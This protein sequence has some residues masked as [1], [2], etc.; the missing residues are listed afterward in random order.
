MR[1]RS[2]PVLLAVAASGCGSEPAV[3]SSGSL[4]ST[5]GRIAFMR[6]TSVDGTDIESVIYAINADGSAERRLT[7]TPGLDGFPTWSPDGTRIAFPSEGTEEVGEI[8]VRNSDGSGL[9]KLTDDPADDSF[10]AWRP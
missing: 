1:P 3:D 2:V 7:D 9:T 8:F 10:P 5:D 6:A 4:V